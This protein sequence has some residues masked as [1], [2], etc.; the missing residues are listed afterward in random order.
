MSN[1]MLIEKDV[2]SDVSERG[3]KEKVWVP[4]TREESRKGGREGRREGAKEERKEGKEDKEEDDNKYH[5]KVFTSF[6]FIFT[7]SCIGEPVLLEQYVVLKNYQKQHGN[8]ISLTKGY[9]VDVIEKH[10]SGRHTALLSYL[11]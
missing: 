3:T 4:D 8:D 11:A 9:A 6:A 10:E 2:S 7:A 1:K 5:S